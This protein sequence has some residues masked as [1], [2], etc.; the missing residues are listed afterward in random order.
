MKIFVFGSNLAGRHGAG[1]AAFAKRHH[2]AV[3]GVGE[4]LTGTAYAIPTKDGRSILN[5]RNPRNILSLDQIAGHVQRFKAFAAEHPEYQF[6]VTMIGC[7][8]AGFKPEEIAP[9]FKDSPSNCELPPEFLAV[10]FQPQ[11][12]GQQA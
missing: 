11:P 9:M 12:E 6:Q 8:H 7:G 5:L 4:G 1:A 10:L 3:Y 2:G